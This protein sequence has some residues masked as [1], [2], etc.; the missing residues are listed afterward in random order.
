MT[1]LSKQYDPTTIEPQIT[2]RWLQAKAFAAT[3]DDRDQRYVIMMPLPN[4]T[5]ALHLGHA[6]DNVMQDLLIRWHRMQGDN[7]LWMAG[8]DHA[9]IGTQ[10]VVEKRLLELEGKTR[11]DVG[12][13]ELVRRIWEWKDQYQERI[14]G[15]QQAMGCSCDW[16]R[17]RFTM[18]DVCA[19]AVRHTFF[20][21]FRDGL[22]YQGHRLVNWDCHLETAVADDELYKAEVQGHFWHLRYPVIDPADGEPTQIVVATT[23]PETMLGDT[24]VACHPD[25]DAALAA[26]LAQAR[27]KLAAAPAKEKAAVEAEIERLEERAVTHLPQLRTIAKMA[28][29]GRQ[30]ML[31]LQDRPIPMICDEW[32]KPELGS[33]CVK[34]TPGHDPNDYEV[35]QRHK[36]AIDIVNI[37]E[38]NGKL[39]GNAGAYAGL[40]R[41]EARQK[42]VA[43]LEEKGLLE[44]VE[45]RAIE[46]DHSDR[47]KTIVE[48][49]LSKQ[50]FVRMSDVEGGVR[51]GVGTDHQHES[52]GL[53]QAAID[54]IDPS[55]KSPTGR[56]VTFHPDERYG[57]TYAA[58]LAEKRDWCISRQLWWG[59]QIPV[60]A[61]KLTPTQMVNIEGIVVPTLSRADVSAWVVLPDESRVT[62]AEAFELC[63]SNPDLG[64]VEV[65]VCFRDLKVEGELASAVESASLRRDPDVLDTWFSSAVW[66]HSTLGWP[67]PESAVV[68]EGQSPL[69]AQGSAPD[70]LSYY[71][72]GSCLV[73]GRDIITLWVARMV[74]MG[75]YNLGDV[76]FTDVF[77][78][79]N[80]QDGKGERMSKSRGNG[81]DPVDMVDR[82][83]ADALRYV[84]C[85]MQTGTQDVRLPVAVDSPFTGN[86]VDL[87]K[88]KHGRTIFSYLC[89]E[90]GKEFDVLGTLDDVPAAKP[91]S[92]RFEVGRNFCNKL[93][94][95]A[96]FAF[97]NL[98]DTPFEPRQLN[99]L[100]LE[101]RWVLSRLAAARDE[102]QR[103][104]EL[105][106]PSA[107]LSAAREFFWAEF[108]D[109]YLE[110]IKPRTRDETQTG[111]VQQVLAAV[112][113]STLRLLHP[114]MPFVTEAL[115]EKLQEA[116]P[117][118]GVDR[119]LAASA[120]L[121][122][123]A[124]P[125][126]RAD[127]RDENAER[128]IALGREVVSTIREMRA[129]HQVPSSQEVEVVLV[130]SNERQDLEPAL[131]LIA[132]LTTAAHIE[133]AE[134]APA[135]RDAATAVVQGIEIFV[136]GIVDVASEKK[137]L[138]GQRDKLAGRITGT[139]K[140]LDNEGFVAKAPPE[141][142]ER[143]RQSL[144][145]LEAQLKSLEASLE[146]LGE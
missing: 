78:H 116:A 144:E 95:S 138:Q 103:Q 131:E 122:H 73:T 89:P 13:D 87:A 107:A 88:A 72:P 106:N 108:C 120:L 68:G 142:V 26:V 114:M 145:T 27:E 121:V 125:E 135:A 67:D 50:W 83:G 98:T 56:R 35:W 82:Y 63:R 33:G 28:R 136:P 99:E 38:P 66:P 62:P 17:Q 11:L 65:Q 134:S 85:E 126:E 129:R 141:V 60:W 40:D 86:P 111:L 12:R 31:P 115:W 80:I 10:A 130:P 54:A 39:N 119:E 102:V 2:E 97:L 22:I 20:R 43:A 4:V 52:P 91:Y 100:P 70:C 44:R 42:V 146:A 23:R 140:K 29:E 1:E 24:A 84:L 93:W 101:D 127:W 14:V 90:S 34:I 46:I 5:G 118:R 58:W 49:Y 48:P 59:H 32:A 137:K 61:G 110:I 96:R 21:M 53:A 132:H 36:D 77:I 18:D 133:L 74:I 51:M 139:R 47:S 64:D 3:P 79:A 71:Y 37:L 105:Y 8:T 45:D 128:S 76:P 81:I 7:S 30:V 92:E 123:A 69:S 57:R 9:G 143:E 19:R 75:L 104:L 16:D 109:W 25:P 55:W 94:N 112:L 117:R 113:D 6:M 15:Q 41:F 124:W